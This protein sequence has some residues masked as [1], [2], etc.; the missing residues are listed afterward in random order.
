MQ[1]CVLSKPIRTPRN[2][3]PIPDEGYCD[4]PRI[5]TL[6]DGTWVAVLTTG[7]GEEG[8]SGQHDFKEHN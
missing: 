1:G 6:A 2:G 4:Q 5:V 8:Q 3:W 7:P